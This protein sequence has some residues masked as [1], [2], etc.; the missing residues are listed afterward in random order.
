M[1]QG[2][3]R[4]LTGIKFGGTEVPHSSM[5]RLVLYRGAGKNLQDKNRKKIIIVY[6]G[7]SPGGL[8]YGGRRAPFRA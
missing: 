2:R 1:T 8:G 3:Q 7:I 4:L 6:L 5:S